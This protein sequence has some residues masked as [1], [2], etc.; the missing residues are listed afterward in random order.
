MYINMFL[1]ITIIGFISLIKN[2]KIERR[3]IFDPG[4]LVLS[5]FSLCYLFPTLAIRYGSDIL[6]LDD[7]ASINVISIYGSLFVSSFIFFYLGISN[8][9]KRKEIPYNIKYRYWSPKSCFYLIL[10]IHA[11][12]KIISISYGIG[13]SDEYADQYIIRM[14]MPVAVSQILN[15]MGGVKFLLTCLLICSTLSKSTNTRNF[16]YLYIVALVFFSDMLLTQARSNF[17]TFCLLFAGSYNFYRQPIGILK[18]ALISLGF[19]LMMGGFAI[20]RSGGLGGGVFGVID[21]LLPSEFIAVYRNALYLVTIAGSSDFIVP[22]G[23]SYLQALIAF[24]PQ[25]VNSGKW[26]PA[27]W[28]VSTY[29]PAYK[30]AGGGL[31]FG[32]IPEAIIN[33]GFASIVFQA[34][35]IVA[36]LRIPYLLARRTIS[37][38][39]NTWI[40]FYFYCFTLIYQMIRSQSFVVFEGLLVGFIIPYLIIF[41]LGSSKVMRNNN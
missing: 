8:F 13:E 5:L 18:E 26:N 12:T 2:Q 6:P 39:V 25:Q 35:I 10:I 1:I 22:P 28:Y 20:V 11:I 17:V 27:D 38:G 23:N 40:L 7:N 24:I 3:T 9:I 31:A 41:T 15:V 32:I 34:F 37:D 21:V 33:F 30:E 4:V 36:T 29:F 19:L 14:S 16:R